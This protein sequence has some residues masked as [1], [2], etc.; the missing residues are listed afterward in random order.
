[1]TIK[2]LT[3]AAAIAVGIA[4]DRNL[5]DI[6]KDILY[7]IPEKY[8]LGLSKEMKEKWKKLSL[9][10]LMTM[11]VPGFPFRAPDDNYM[12]FSFSIK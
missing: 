6:S 8:T 7:Y 1:M 11:S 10:R 5:I 3:V 12:D 9:Y 2:K 4:L